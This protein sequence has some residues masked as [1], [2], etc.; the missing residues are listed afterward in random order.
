[1]PEKKAINAGILKITGRK[2]FR[3]KLSKTSPEFFC[4]FPP[5]INGRKLYLI[6]LL[7]QLSFC[8]DFLWSMLILFLSN[9]FLSFAGT[10][11]SA[12]P[13]KQLA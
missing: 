5:L 10:L 7:I 12:Y 9:F 2:Y 1:M 13:S 3:N 8:L 4:I 11:K 6:F